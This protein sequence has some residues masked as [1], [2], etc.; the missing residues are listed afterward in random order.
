MTTKDYGSAVSAHLDPEGRNWETTVYQSGKPVL[1]KELNLVQDTEQDLGLRFR[2]RTFPSGWIASDFLDT[3]DMSSA[4]YS[5]SAN[6]NELEIPQDL[7]AHVNGWLIRVGHTNTNGANILDLGAGPAGA[8][9]KRT[10]LV[11]LEVWRRLLDATTGDGKSGS[12]RIWWYGNVKIDGADDLTLNFADDLL[13]AM[14]GAETTRRVQIQYRLRVIQDIDVFTNPYG[15][16]DPG[17]VAHSVPAAAAAPDGVA[18]AF[19]YTN[20]SAAGDSGL[21]RAGDG[22]PANAIGS[23]DGYMYAIPLMAV[24]RRNT[25]AFDK[26]TNHNGGVASPGPSDRPDGFFHDIVAAQ[27]VHDLRLGVSP[28]G[29]SY[30]ELLERNFNWLMDNVIQTE[31][32]ATLVGGGY[33]GHTVLSADEIGITNGNGGDGTTTGDTPG[34]NFIGQFDAGRRHFSD[35]PVIETIMVA[36]TPADASGGGPNWQGNDVLTIDPTSLPVY[37][38]A[39]FNWAAYAPANFTIL[40]VDFE[41]SW[42]LGT[43]AMTDA[44]PLF[45]GSGGAVLSGTGAVPQGSLTLDLGAFLPA[46]VTNQTLYLALYVAYPSGQGLTRTPTG[47]FGTD[48]ISVNN[49]GQLPAGNPIAF[50]AI[51]DQS[52]DFPHRELFLTYI[53]DTAQTFSTNGPASATFDDVIQMPER[54]HSVTNI[55]INA[56]AYGGSVTIENDGYAL[57]LDP[58]SFSSGDVADVTYQAIRPFPQNDEQITI[59]YEARMPQTIR[60]A[61]LPASLTL[62]PRYIPEHIYSLTVG[63]GSQDEAYPFPYQYVQ[64]PG[65]YPTSGGTFSGDHDFSSFGDTIIRDFS[66]NG[67]QLRLPAFVG[68]VPNPQEATFERVGGDVDA[69]GRSFFKEVPAGYIPNSA[70]QSLRGGKVHRVVHPFLAELAADSTVGRKG[71]LVLAVLSGTYLVPEDSNQIVFNATLANNRASL[72]IYRL[73]GN[74]LNGRVA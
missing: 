66:A 21:W 45:R 16:D 1:D 46:G 63:S 2:R 67:G 72:S 32:S 29:W 51:Q 12:G 14:V 22:N 44:V 64:M 8:A 27:D 19:G 6:A 56:G 54:V 37:P 25:T 74:L 28:T 58:A 65:V 26:N 5:L 42:W 41:N 9:T 23:V 59:Y 53:T 43:G 62:I 34:A 60:T 50:S 31:P 30:H 20:Q 61:N 35:R 7:R 11:I 73:K 70:G 52:F 48:S 3:S 10:D 49:P 71:Q 47:D 40:G 33:N 24:F 13:D 69:E 68:Y 17:V 38:Y 39:A 4:I 57:S 15:I 18:T 55:D 36:Y